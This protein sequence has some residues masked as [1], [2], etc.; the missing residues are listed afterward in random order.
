[1]LTIL[2]KTMTAFH[3]MTVL[4]WVE[5]FWIAT[6]AF[7]KG[8]EGHFLL[9]ALLQ[10]ATMSTVLPFIESWAM[11][12]VR[13]RPSLGTPHLH[14]GITVK[15]IADSWS[16]CRHLLKT[17]VIWAIWD[18]GFKLMGQWQ[19]PFYTWS[20]TWV[21]IFYYT[22]ICDWFCDYYMYTR[23]CRL[24]RMKPKDYT[25]MLWHHAITIF[26]M[27]G[28]ASLGYFA[29]GTSVLYLHEWTDI[30]ISTVKIFRSTRSPYLVPVFAV[31]LIIWFGARIVWFIPSLIL[32]AWSICSSP[33]MR[34]MAGCLCGLWCMHV[35]WFGLMTWLA[36]SL[37][38][39]SP[40]QVSKMYDGASSGSSSTP[41]S[42]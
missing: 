39:A 31:N 16:L 18:P 20:Q 29:I 12:F 1:M 5:A 30:F 17:A 8:F 9:G 35:Y 36:I 23:S 4:I 2:K 27:G 14:E 3:P 41:S 13:Q 38:R 6:T 10:A 25:V 37:T 28:S 11:E 33:F 7:W 22:C 32:P 19:G 21:I 34:V 40:S 42:S 24:A 26:L 15:I